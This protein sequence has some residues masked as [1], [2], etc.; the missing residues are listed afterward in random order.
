MKLYFLL[1]ILLASS[2]FSVDLNDFRPYELAKSQSVMG[3]C[4]TRTK[5]V[6][7]NGKKLDLK[8]FLVPVTFRIGRLFEPTSSILTGLRFPFESGES[9]CSTHQLLLGSQD[10]VFFTGGLFNPLND[11][12]SEN[13]VA[14]DSLNSHEFFQG[15]KA[16]HVF[17]R[18]AAKI[19]AHNV[20]NGTGQNKPYIL[21]EINIV[22]K[23]NLSD[24]ANDTGWYNHEII[25]GQFKEFS[26]PEFL[27]F[28]NES[29]LKEFLD[30]PLTTPL[31]KSYEKG[32]Q[33]LISRMGFGK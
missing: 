23:S 10:K 8:E 32:I 2:A 12:F 17:R 19:M 33:N 1:N 26:N 20:N 6:F 29:E 16:I 18:I 27:G 31:Q 21:L 22:D 11:G 4:A 9:G 5:E 30:L 14:F 7:E 3:N 25:L 28:D 15:Q 13:V 24:R